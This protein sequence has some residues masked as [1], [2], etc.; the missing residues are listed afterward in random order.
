[1]HS[2]LTH[3]VAVYRIQELRQTA[4]R[5]RRAAPFAQARA[6]RVVRDEYPDVFILPSGARLVGRAVERADRGRIHELFHRLS[7][8]SRYRRYF[9]PKPRLSER[10]LT[11][12]SDIDHV[13]H[14]AIAAVDACDGSFAGIVR[15]VRRRDWPQAADLAIEVADDVQRMGVGT[16][17]TAR[18]LERTR[19]LGFDIVTATSLRQN[20]PARA[21]LKRFSFEPYASA[22]QEIELARRLIPGEVAGIAT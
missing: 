3:A 6:A 18:I 5:H 20:V 13:A 21:L 15:V 10:E 9:S 16:W 19:E 4:D 11:Y 7:E 17:L 22:G 12:L 2:Y 1:M 14:E 8:E